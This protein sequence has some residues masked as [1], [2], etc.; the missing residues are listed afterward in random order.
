MCKSFRTIAYNRQDGYCFY[1]NIKM[2][3]INGKNRNYPNAG[4]AEHII[5][6]SKG[7]VKNYYNIV[8]A[9]KE[10]N[11]IRGNIDYEIFINMRTKKDWKKRAKEANWSKEYYYKM[12]VINQL[13]IGISELL[14]VIQ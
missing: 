11:N 4:T 9:C 12:K 5:P 7:G 14:K 1:C 10:C 6:Q 13:V 8:C 3:K 2:V